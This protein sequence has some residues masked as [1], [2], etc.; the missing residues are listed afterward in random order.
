MEMKIFSGTANR[1]LAEEVAD[2]LGVKLGGVQISR[3]ASGEIYVRY[4]ESIRGV[5][6]FVIQPFSQPTNDNN[7]ELLIRLDA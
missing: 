2:F 5:D 7:M 4:E 3:F 1:K 6:T